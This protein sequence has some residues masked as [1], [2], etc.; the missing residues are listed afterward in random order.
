VG[1]ESAF[2]FVRVEHDGDVL[3]AALAN[4]YECGFSVFWPPASRLVL[5]CFFEAW[6]TSSG[7]LQHRL[8]AAFAQACSS[9][10][11]AA[12]GLLTA[13]ADFPDDEPSAI[14]LVS[15][16]PPSAP[17]WAHQPSAGGSSGRE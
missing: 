10:V 9:F 14:L 17:A 2:D 1:S 16:T 5:D 4:G 11:A 7:P 15:V 8:Y 13:D 6:R 3:I 12:P